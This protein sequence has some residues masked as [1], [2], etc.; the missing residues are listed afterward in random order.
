MGAL[1]N[2]LR[3]HSAETVEN[4][5]SLASFDIVHG[6]LKKGKRETCWKSETANSVENTLGHGDL[7]VD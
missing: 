6:Q 5:C 3:L 2:H 1:T 4:H 7:S